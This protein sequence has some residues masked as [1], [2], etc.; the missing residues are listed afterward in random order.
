M[1]K[2][3]AS[4]TLNLI[5]CFFVIINIINVDDVSD[6]ADFNVQTGSLRITS[7]EAI[8]QTADSAI[9]D[10]GVPLYGATLVGE[11][12]VPPTGEERG[13]APLSKQLVATSPNMPVIALLTRGDCFFVEKVHNAQQAGAAAAIIMDNVDEGLLTMANPVDNPSVDVIA[14]KVVIPST[15]VAKSV[16]EAM[17]GALKEGSRV[18]V[19]MDWKESISHP[20]DRVEYEFWTTSNDGCGPNCERQAAFKRDFKEKAIK[21]DQGKHTLSTPHFLMW[22]CTNHESTSSTT[23]KE[24]CYSQCIRGGRYCDPTASSD[25][26]SRSEV[27]GGGGGIKPV[28]GR[29][30]MAENLRQLC[31]HR[32][33]AQ[34]GQSWVWWEYASRYVDECPATGSGSRG[35]G[36]DCSLRVMDD[37]SREFRGAIDLQ[38]IE[39]CVG[40][41]DED[42]PHPLLDE[43]SK[44][45]AGSTQRTKVIL[46][47]TIMINE[48]QYRGRLDV[49]SVMHGLCAGFD[50]STEPAACLSSV[51]ERNEC[52]RDNDFGGC[53]K[54]DSA[55][56]FHA[57]LDTFRG[58]RCECP[59]GFRDAAGENAD[60]ET[61]GKSCRD[62][63][64]CDEGTHE[65]DQ[66]C[67]NTV[68]SYRCLCAPGY[69]L[70]LDRACFVSDMCK[71]FPNGGCGAHAT[72]ISDPVEDKRFDGREADGRCQCDDGYVLDP[73][74]IKMCIKEHKFHEGISI[75][76]FVLGSIVV[77]L[78]LATIG[79][80]LYKWRLRQ[81]MDAEIRQ[82]LSQYMPLDTTAAAGAAAPAPP[83]E[84]GDEFTRDFN[85]SYHEDDTSTMPLG[86]I[87]ASKKAAVEEEEQRDGNT[88]NAVV[89]DMAVV[90]FAEEDD[91]DDKDN[92]DRR[93]GTTAN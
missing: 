51:I 90:R 30:V 77:V 73:H 22:H 40:D 80:S 75:G 8:R 41:V 10:F 87:R 7:P 50:E 43:E 69:R 12:V 64:E 81:H 57:C 66:T 62:I 52:T 18:V 3:F 16:G 65:C 20:D 46:L 26:Q 53:W 79:Y 49:Q 42:L 88:T 32:N 27:M 1:M 54:S 2:S 31:L 23:D 74:N 35:F 56:T 89:H 4:S 19:E 28:L 14:E 37:I 15:L 60:L 5:F 78:L 39:S 11:V 84:F 82:V 68:G 55:G 58:Y 13:C 59:S 36:R 6:A 86:E 44:L 93:G 38:K 63:D 47:P 71:A 91:D 48:R 70:V 29:E 92:Q 76:M 72:C 33:A 85:D 45:Q 34:N 67:E 83:R 25:E 9:G 21:F 24:G 61:K 17:R